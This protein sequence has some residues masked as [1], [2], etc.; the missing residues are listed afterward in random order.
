LV[1]EQEGIAVPKVI[2]F[3]IAKEIEQGLDEQDGLTS[4]NQFLGTPAYMHKCPDITC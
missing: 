3:G 2:D 4:M 1:T